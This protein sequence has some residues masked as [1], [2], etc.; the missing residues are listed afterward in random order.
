MPFW[1]LSGFFVGELTGKALWKLVENAQRFPRR[2]GRVLRPRRRQLP[3]GARPCATRWL[4]GRGPRVISNWTAAPVGNYVHVETADLY[5]PNARFT[6]ET[7]GYQVL[8]PFGK[9]GYSQIN[10]GT[11]SGQLTE[12]TM[13]ARG[14]RADHLTRGLA[15][16]DGRRAGRRV[17]P[18]LWGPSGMSALANVES[19]HHDP[20]AASQGSLAVRES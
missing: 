18:P 6:T 1:G 19:V 11:G 10:D 14:L 2:G 17:D 3:Q 8:T 9:L 16:G 12:R 15:G 4:P 7:Q 20:N 5:R 13:R